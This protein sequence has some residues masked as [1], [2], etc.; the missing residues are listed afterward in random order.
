LV[1]GEKE[2]LLLDF[3]TDRHIPENLSAEHPYVGQLAA[4]ALALKQAYGDRSIRAA[5]LWTDLPRLDW[6]PAEALEK[7]MAAITSAW[8]T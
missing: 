8:H 1:V 4:Y 6:L 2:I 3:K 7:G 5:L